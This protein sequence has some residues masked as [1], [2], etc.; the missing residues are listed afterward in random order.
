MDSGGHYLDGTTDLTRVL[1]FGARP[2]GDLKTNYTAVLQ[3]NLDLEREVW[4]EGLTGDHFDAIARKPLQKLGL[5]YGH[6]TGHGV[7]SYLCVHEGPVSLSPN[8]TKYPIQA[9]MSL[10]N[11]PGYYKEGEYGIRIENILLC[12][13]NSEGLLYWKNLDNVPY[14]RKLIDKKVIDEATIHHIDTYHSKCY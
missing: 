2:N 10:S 12:Q 7:G 14:E 8:A 3:G 1:Y 5:N 4:E 6:G 13:K 11:E 9:G